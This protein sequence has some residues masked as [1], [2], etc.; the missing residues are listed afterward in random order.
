M[1]N[2][3][4]TQQARALLRAHH[5]GAIATLSK[6]L[7]GYPFASVVD[8]L[9]D[10][11]ARP[12]LLIRALAQHAQNIEQDARVSLLVHEDSDKAQTSTRLTLSGDAHR[13]EF[14]TALKTRYLRYFPSAASYFTTSDFAFYRIDPPQLRYIDEFGDIHWITPTDFRPPQN[15]LVTTEDALLDHMNRDHTASLQAYCNQ[16][17]GKKASDATLVGIDCDGFDVRTDGELLRVDFPRPVL[18]TQQASEALAAMARESR[19]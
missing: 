18:S 10:E 5:H 3:T 19:E 11:E 4:P 8:Y 2:T 7:D 13:L 6:Q 14:S 1:N 12:I 17:Y 15:M 16:F 9:L